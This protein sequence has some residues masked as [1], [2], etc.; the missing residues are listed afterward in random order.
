MNLLKKNITNH[1][2]KEAKTLLINR[3]NLAL[4]KP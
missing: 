1:K 3:D 4:Q 2:L